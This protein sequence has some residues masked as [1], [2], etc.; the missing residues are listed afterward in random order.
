MIQT[1]QPASRMA[2]WGWRTK[3]FDVICAGEALW[4]V[5]HRG[6]PVSSKAPPVSPGGGPV[7]VALALAS[8]GLHVGLATVLADDALGRGSVKRIAA[9]GVD[10]GGVTFA[11]P[12]K[13]FVIIDASG[14]AS[15]V[16]SD[17]EAEPP[18]EVPVGW[19]SQVLLLSGLSPV[20]SHAAALCKAARAARRNGSFVL[21]DFNASLHV[22]AGRDPRTIRMVL[23]EVDAARCSLAD[24]AVLGM[25]VA[26]VRGVLRQ[27]AVLVVSDG[28]GGA[29]ATGPFGDVAFVPPQGTRLR[30]TGAGDAW[31]AAICLE[32]TRCAEPGQSP[33]ARWF[34]ALRRGHA[35]TSATV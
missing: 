29:V 18:L 4:K 19:S 33:N 5:T 13:G 15:Q 14:G 9:A 8:E 21:I 6:K 31:T 23:R 11:R 1:M 25:D 28:K 12:R 3:N 2:Q 16:P 24:L 30:T 34:R 7:T 20:I 17:V 32:L 27:G 10:V 22:W 26:T 35:A